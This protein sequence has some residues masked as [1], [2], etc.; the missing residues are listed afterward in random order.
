MITRFRAFFR[1]F[2]KVFAGRRIHVA[3]LGFFGFLSGLFEGIGI[4]MLV[5]LFALLLQGEGFGGDRISRFIQNVF[6]WFGLP[7]SVW[8]LLVAMTV[9]FF[10]KA[11]ALLVFGYIR[12]KIIV[13][14]ERD[15]RKEAYRKFLEAEWPY[16]LNQKIGHLENVLMNDVNI[17]AAFLKQVSAFILD[18]TNFAVYSVAAL[19]ISVKIT[20]L[21]LGGGGAL[22]V[23]ARPLLKRTKFF[24]KRRME[25][26]KHI[27]HHVN[28]HMVGL[29][30][31]KA[32]G[33]EK[34]VSD[35]GAGFFED[36]RAIRLKQYLVQSIFGAL[37]QPLS[38]VFIIGIFAFFYNQP[39]FSLPAF[40]AVIYLIQKIFAYVNDIQQSISAMLDTIPSVEK[41]AEIKETSEAARERFSG[42]H[43]FRFQKE[44]CFRGVSFAYDS[45]KEVL[46]DVSFSIQRGEIMG[47][48]GI[49][50]SGKTTIADLL[51][52]LFRP[53]SGVITVD[54]IDLQSVSLK[55][56]RKKIGYVSQEVFLK[57]DTIAQ[58]IRFY[59]PTISEEAMI[60]STRAANIYDFIQT[61]P[62]KFET[63]IGERGVM[64]SGGQRQRIALARVLARRPEL[65]IL[66]EATSAI[67]TESEA[68]IQESIE[69]LRGRVT[70]LVIAHRLSTVLSADR[71]IV[72]D[73]GKIIEEGS[74]QEL[75][76]DTHSYFSRMH[77][78]S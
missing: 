71:I 31:V 16:L 45:K 59:D 23:L 3:A 43:S 49:S 42:E 46:S 34:A 6:L 21:T 29:K 28:E 58:N 14:Y 73:R 7:L 24:A 44:I 77:T 61:L 41:I 35:V 36:F 17:G 22:L 53:T 62:K 1:V 32:F 27:A 33:V 26:Y 55:E 40:I 25:I 48:V 20:L 54:G 12:T 47:I 18:I 38:M 57:N 37:I 56:M 50:G 63:I 4:S 10:V 13:D 65:L 66:D 15:T 67:D 74:P 60:E 30:L 5:P 51:L 70:I 11:G 52:R 76:K 64:L 75:L 8:S 9:L 78:S 68:A 69:Q 72:L 19:F 2:Q 39:G